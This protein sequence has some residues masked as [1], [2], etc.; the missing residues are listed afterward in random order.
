MGAAIKYVYG[1]IT[2]TAGA[3]AA[4]QAVGSTV[5][6]PRAFTS[7]KGVAFVRSVSL[8][9]NVAVALAFDIVLCAS[10]NGTLATDKN[11]WAPSSAGISGSPPTVLSRVQFVAAD[12]QTYGTNFVANKN[13]LYIPVYAVPN[14]LATAL[15]DSDK[16]GRSLC[17][18]MVA[19]GAA[20]YGAISMKLV[21][22]LS[23]E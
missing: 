1:D 19:Q 20:T 7:P 10:R 21:V 15:N 14:A 12:I 22:G 16:E 3:Y 23:D 18:V 11:A 5:S 8:L 9:G 2:A 13:G 6:L 4:G 17:A